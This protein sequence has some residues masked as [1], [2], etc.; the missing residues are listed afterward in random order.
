MPHCPTHNMLAD[1]LTKP[2]T[3]GIAIPHIKTMAGIHTTYNNMQ[4]LEHTQDMYAS[5]DIDN[6]DD[7]MGTY[8]MAIL[9]DSYEI[10]ENDIVSQIQVNMFLN[11]HSNE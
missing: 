6:D 4:S 10:N 9:D 1:P 5:D 11:L 8:T 3:P 2:L 7:D